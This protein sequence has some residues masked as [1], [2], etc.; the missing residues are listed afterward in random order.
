MS[1]IAPAP[2]LPGMADLGPAEQRHRY[3]LPNGGEIVA[4]FRGRHRFERYANRGEGHHAY[5]A[6]LDAG[7]VKQTYGQDHVRPRQAA[8][9]LG[10][11]RRK[12]KELD[13][14]G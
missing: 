10:I 8:A 3:A 1:R 14:R 5:T 6:I 7:A 13:A 12:C 4:Y 9:H 11:W 2:T